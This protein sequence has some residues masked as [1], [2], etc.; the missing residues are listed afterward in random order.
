VISAG[1]KM[2]ENN[3]AAFNSSYN[4]AIAP[5]L[6]VESGQSSIPIEDGESSS[7]Y[8]LPEASPPQGK[9]LLSRIKTTF[10]NACY[11]FI[12]LGVE[13]LLDYQDADYAVQYLDKLEDILKVDSGHND[14]E[15]SRETARYLALWMSY[16]DTA[17]VAQIKTRA[18]RQ[19]KIRSEV[20]ADDEQLIHVTDFFAP[21]LEEICQPLPAWLARKIIASPLCRKLSAPL[22]KGKRIRTDT[23]LSF[24]LLR[25]MAFT[26]KWRRKH[27]S[28]EHEHGIVKGYGKTR[29]RGSRQISKLLELCALKNLS[30]EQIE[31]QRL[32]A[33][34][35]ESGDS[36]TKLTESLAQASA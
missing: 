27:Y 31:Q 30:A 14:Y 24:S 17:R 6:I 8:S 20:K 35:D 16:E 36:F 34:D 25:M 7:V 15:L 12:T 32:S 23:I 21:R 26:A 11:P 28:Y 4:K 18:S 9:Q 3:L 2:V 19:T 22:T 29:E 1:G 33:L 13:R 5:V 10:P